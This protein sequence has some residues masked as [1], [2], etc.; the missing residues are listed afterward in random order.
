[1]TPY[2]REIRAA[3]CAESAVIIFTV[4]YRK[5]NHLLAL[6]DLEDEDRSNFRNVENDSPTNNVVT[7]HKTVPSAGL[8]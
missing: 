3:F 7:S 5:N 6:P 4:K 8:L 2:G 1:V